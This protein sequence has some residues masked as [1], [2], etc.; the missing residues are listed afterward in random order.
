MSIDPFCYQKKTN[1]INK[2]LSEQAMRK[3]Y[4]IFMQRTKEFYHFHLA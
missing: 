1:K 4:T 2:R 3:I